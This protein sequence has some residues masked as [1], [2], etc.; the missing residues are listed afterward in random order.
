MF[1]RFEEDAVRAI[2]A[3]RDETARLGHPAVGT[4]H[5]LVGLAST[6]AR[7]ARLIADQGGSVEALVRALVALAGQAKSQRTSD[8][9]FGPDAQRAIAQSWA[10][11]EEFHH[12]TI[13]PGHLLLAI[14]N[15][16][17]EASRASA[18]LLAAGLDP[19]VLAGATRKALT[20][21]PRPNGRGGFHEDDLELS[22]SYGPVTL[23]LLR[24]PE[25]GPDAARVISL[26]ADTLRGPEE[27][28]TFLAE[29]DRL[30]DASAGDVHIRFLKDLFIGLGN[31][32]ATYLES[33]ARPTP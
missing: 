4:E 12:S 26:S 3:G 33:G 13:A 31:R 28:R 17:P 9:P 22:T 32:L 8:L 23:T 19:T 24:K 27:V 25:A 16:G 30:L 15:Q 11:A 6:D 1:E 14:L 7:V 18:L 5:L 2:L 10:I 29:L 20:P 21:A